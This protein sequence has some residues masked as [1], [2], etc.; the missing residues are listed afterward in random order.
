LKLI[1]AHAHAYCW[2][3]N[4]NDGCK[5]SSLVQLLGISQLEMVLILEKCE[6]LDKETKEFAKKVP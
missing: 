4:G 3:I 1:G 2:D 5:E 6:S